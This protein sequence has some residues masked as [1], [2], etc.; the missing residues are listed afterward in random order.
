M[1]K[2]RLVS[3]RVV[4][5]TGSLLSPDRNRFISLDQA[6]P[7]LGQPT[8]GSLVGSFTDGSRYFISGSETNTVVSFN[9]GTKNWEA[10]RYINWDQINPEVQEVGLTGSIN[11]SGSFFLN[12]TNIL[13]QIEESGIFRQT[14]SFWSTTN[15]LQVTGSF[16][17]NLPTGQT[18]EVSTE[19]QKKV[20]INQEG[21]LVLTP[22]E[23]TPTPVS[24][25]V[26]YSAS[27]EFFLGL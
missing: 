9:T 24:G 13:E 27:N 17:I 3:G 1:S 4:A 15:N 20:E 19:G 12:D 16:S 18:F 11:L 26:I 5:L 7:N 8:T 23:S 22:F 14:G 25:G 6:E 21:V 10:T 2:S